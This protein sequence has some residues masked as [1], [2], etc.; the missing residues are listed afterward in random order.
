MAT[1]TAIS[2]HAESNR[3][4][5]DDPPIFGSLSLEV[6]VF[7]HFSPL[8]SNVAVKVTFATS[9]AGVILKIPAEYSNPD[10]TYQILRKIN[11]E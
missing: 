3:P 11:Y 4:V 6:N 1:C 8:Y 5:C 2:S 10:L 7:D 9:I